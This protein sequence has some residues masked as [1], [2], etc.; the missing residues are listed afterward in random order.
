[1]MRQIEINRVIVDIDINIDIERY[2]DG[3][4]SKFE[5]G[6]RVRFDKKDGTVYNFNKPWVRIIF[7]D[8]TLTGIKEKI[9]EL[10]KRNNEIDIM[11]DDLI[12][13]IV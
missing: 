6:D 3:F 12:R 13:E 11:F 7:D 10:L 9:I 5:V 1:M 8:C 4:W 2:D